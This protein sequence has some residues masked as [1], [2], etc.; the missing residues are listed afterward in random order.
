MTAHATDPFADIFAPAD[1]VAAGMA[2]LE[3]S[4]PLWGTLAEWHALVARLKAFEQPWGGRARLAGWQPLELYG[5]HPIA[6]RTRLSA[7]GAAFI[8][9]LRAHQVVDV[10][11]VG[12]MLVSRTAARLRILRGRPDTEAVLAWCK[13]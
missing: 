3:Q 1:E 8:V 13:G 11:H 10:D 12:L 5:L 4:P 2:Q 7:M 6:P 9:A